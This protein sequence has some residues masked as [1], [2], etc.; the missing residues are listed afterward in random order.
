MKKSLIS[1]ALLLASSVA[2]ADSSYPQNQVL[3]PLTLSEGTIFVGGSLARSEENDDQRNQLNF[4]LAYGLTDN[5]TIGLGGLDYRILARPHNGS[6]LE[7]SVGAGI[8]GFQESKVNGDALGLG[9]DLNAKYVMNKN[10]A[11]LFT[12]GYVKWDEEKLE[13]KDEIRYSIGLQ[14]NV[15][16]NWTANASYTYRDLKDFTQDKAHAVNIGLNYAY[17]RHSDIGIFAGYSNFDAQENGY[18]LDNSF[19]RIAGVYATFRF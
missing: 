15:A 18:D 8:R 16:K 3:R 5:L 12:L 1:V 4:D 14:T 11:L 13:N 9:A 6:G 17:S 10:L 7:V 19:D 2:Y